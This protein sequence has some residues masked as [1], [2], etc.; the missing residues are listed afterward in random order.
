MPLVR[1]RFCELLG[2]YVS[3]SESVNDLFLLGLLSAVD[4]IL[5]M[6][7]DG[8]LKEIA[9]GSDIRDALLGKPNPVRRIVELMLQYETGCWEEM[10]NSAER[11]GIDESKISPLYIESIDWAQQILLGGAGQETESA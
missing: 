7:M 3:R 10:A 6:P 9:I 2:P 8:V 4:A 11:L 1:A 5:D